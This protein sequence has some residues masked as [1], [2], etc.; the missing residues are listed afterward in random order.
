MREKLFCPVKINL[1]LR[2]LSPRDDGYHNIY[3]LFWQKKAIEGLTICSSDDENIGDVLDVDGFN[4][5]GINLVTKAV[6][7]MRSL[8]CAV[9][10]L[11]MRLEKHYPA[12]SGIGAGSGN[13]AAAIRW[14]SEKYAFPLSAAVIAQLGAD[15]A[16][17]ASSYDT[18]IASGVG[19]N[20]REMP[21]IPGLIWV[22][23]FPKWS[24]QTAEAYKKLDIYRLENNITVSAG[25]F[26]A[27]AREVH[28]LLTR[29]NYIGLLPNDFLA[30]LTKE[31]SEYSCAGKIA[32][33]SGA[34]AWGL[35]G[36][37]SAYFAVCGDNDSADR[38][39]EMYQNENW[40]L[41][42]SKLE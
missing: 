23:V 1:T 32:K 33:D 3:S 24:S 20:L 26:E 17:L 41:K 13:A 4:L 9:P 6:A 27:E 29:K 12:G 15:V 42:T 40:I 18:A 16:F 36:S 39:V 38:A 30:P 11:R 28:E 8:G 21:S 35:C 19:E 7:L 37:G 34:L 25:D 31:H 2:V 10:P 5:M 14:I 22:L